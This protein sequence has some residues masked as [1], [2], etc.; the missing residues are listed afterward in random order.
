MTYQTT[1]T[2]KG[3]ITIPKKFRDMLKLNKFRK[4]E[5][6]MQKDN[7]AVVIKPALDFLEVA[8][9]IKVRKKIDA[10]KAREMLETN[11]ERV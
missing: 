7:Q 1:V 5:V 6:E 9:R 8:R 3:Q 11:Y 4:V 2:T 10:L